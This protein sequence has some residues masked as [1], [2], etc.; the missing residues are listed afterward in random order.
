MHASSG[1]LTH[2]FFHSPA[3]LLQALPHGLPISAAFAESAV[4]EVM[5]KRMNKNQRMRWNR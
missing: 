4:N 3:P 1:R 5:A 2:G